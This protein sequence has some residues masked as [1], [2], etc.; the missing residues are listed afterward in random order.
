VPKNE[1][2]WR[3]LALLISILALFAA[4]PLVV[5]FTHGVLILNIVG[6]AVLLAGSYALSER[7]HLFAIAIALSL[8][9][10]ITTWLLLAYPKR[11]TALVSHSCLVVLLGFFSVTILGYVLRRGRITSDICRHLRLFAHRVCVDIFLCAA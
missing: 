1:N 8:L 7:K 3:H 5:P 11:W 10:V 6:V 9:S 2:P 4:A